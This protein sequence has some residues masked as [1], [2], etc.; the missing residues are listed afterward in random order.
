MTIQGRIGLLMGTAAA[1]SVALAAP[2]AAQTDVVNNSTIVNIDAVDNYDMMF[3]D[4]VG[5][6]VSWTFA[7]GGSGNGSWSSLGGGVY[8][9]TGTGSGNDYFSLTSLGA[10]DTYGLLGVD[11]FVWDLKGYGV[12]G[13]TMDALSSSL[14]FDIQSFP[15]VG[16]PGSSYGNP[17]EYPCGALCLIFE[18]GNPDRWNTTATYTQELALNGDPNSPY[19]DEWGMLNVAFGDAFSCQKLTGGPKNCEVYFSQDVD[20]VTGAGN[21]EEVP[22]PGTMSLLAFGLAGL[23]GAG[24]RRLR[25]S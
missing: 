10:L 14:A 2:A 20:H 17:Y 6:N 13:F 19:G 1:C 22:E 25:R 7:D 5:M 3:S 11:P 24:R 8:G 18:G 23:A 9:V 12:S 16:T 15:T 21:P 4:L